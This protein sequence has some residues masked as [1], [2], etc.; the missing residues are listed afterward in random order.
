MKALMVWEKNITAESKRKTAVNQV[1]EKFCR[2][3][4][5]TYLAAPFFVTGYRLGIYVETAEKQNSVSG[6]QSNVKYL[7]KRRYIYLRVR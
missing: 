7:P 3:G 5:N 6:I 1:V 4:E 2:Q